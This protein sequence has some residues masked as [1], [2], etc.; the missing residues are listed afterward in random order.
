MVT[1]SMPLTHAQDRF[2]SKL[3]R[4]AMMAAALFLTSLMTI[5]FS[6]NDAEAQ[7][8]VRSK[9]GDGKSAA[10][11]LRAPHQNSVP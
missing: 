7:G 10:T 8:A 9:H 4:A 3:P 11:R 5:G 1:S 2:F 6:A